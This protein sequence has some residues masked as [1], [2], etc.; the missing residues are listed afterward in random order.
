LIEKAVADL[1]KNGDMIEQ[2][3]RHYIVGYIVKKLQ[4]GAAKA[5]SERPAMRRSAKKTAK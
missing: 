4:T 5:R 3:P 2:T 1:V